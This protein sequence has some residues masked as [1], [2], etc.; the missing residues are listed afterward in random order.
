MDVL[1]EGHLEEN[2]RF[3]MGRMQSQAP[4]VDG[5]VF[6]KEETSRSAIIGSI[7]NVEITDR[8]IYDLYAKIS[9]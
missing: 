1:I 2:P 8:D 5:V 7:Q 4:E 9:R 3:L 6:I